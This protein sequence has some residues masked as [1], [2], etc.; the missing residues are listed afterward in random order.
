[1]TT[2]YK[3]MHSIVQLVPTQQKHIQN[4]SIFHVFF[5]WMSFQPSLLMSE[6]HP[7][8]F[9]MYFLCDCIHL[10]NFSYRC[11]KNFLWFK[12]KVFMMAKC[13]SM[14]QKL[15]SRFEPWASASCIWG[16]HFTWWA[17]YQMIKYHFLVI[18]PWYICP[19]DESW[20]NK[21]R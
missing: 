6:G 10:F 20:M 12:I 16:L 11:L 2:D 15:Y 9:K 13:Y 5:Y 1:M 17:T 18:Q 21:T 8:R 4:M 14:Q 3:V 7:Y 19:P